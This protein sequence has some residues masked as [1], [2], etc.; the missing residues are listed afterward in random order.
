MIYPYLIGGDIG[1]GMS[2]L[3]LPVDRSKLGSD[4]RRDRFAQ[5]IGN[6]DEPYAGRWLSLMAHRPT[7]LSDAYF[8]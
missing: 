6:L 2:L 3:Q 4:K 7:S 1:C 8:T 5:L